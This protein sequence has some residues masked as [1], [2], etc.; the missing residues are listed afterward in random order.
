[1]RKIRSVLGSNSKVILHTSSNTHQNIPSERP[2]RLQHR[3]KSYT[4]INQ[5]L[6]TT[7]YKQLLSHSISTYHFPKSLI[8]ATAAIIRNTDG[9]FYTFLPRTLHSPLGFYSPF[10]LP[11]F[12][13]CPFHFLLSHFSFDSNHSFSFHTFHVIHFCRSV[14]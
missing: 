13:H 9:Y 3:R 7:N 10:I 14:C 12:F 6:S 5:S 11:S 4:T 8:S 2:Q 1:M